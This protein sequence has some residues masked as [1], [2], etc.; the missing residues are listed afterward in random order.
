MATGNHEEVGSLDSRV[1]CKPEDLLRIRGRIV[2]CE[3]GRMGPVRFTARS[4][5]E[6]S[7]LWRVT[8][9]V[10]EPLWRKFSTGVLTRGTWTLEQECAM[11]TA[12]LQ[13]V[14]VGH[15]IDIGCSTGVY[16]RAILSYAPD[17]G[18]ILV[19]YSLPMLEK[20]RLK[21]SGPATSGSGTSGPGTSDGGA[22]RRD[23]AGGTTAASE[24]P[25]I[26]EAKAGRDA[27]CDTLATYLQC[28]AAA[29]PMA[30]RSVDGAV[31]G[32]TLNELTEPERVLSEL[33]RVLKTGASAVIM[34]LART[35]RAGLFT[36]MLASGGVWI[37]DERGADAMFRE[38]GFEIVDTRRAGIMRLV[39][40]RVSG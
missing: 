15:Y 19:D 7:N 4:M 5:A 29:L 35:G 16:A 40:L 11:M 1:P 22:A 31:M 37:P 32:G 28:D 21:T 33:A 38:A 8:S 2:T 27:G 17:C 18:V 30:D 10:Y 20:A 3:S 34:H 26:N 9:S 24:A 6:R 14:S 36:R 13:P 23:T 39:H 12:M 25:G